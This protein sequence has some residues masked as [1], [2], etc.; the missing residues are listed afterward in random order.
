MNKEKYPP[1]QG[2]LG[3]RFCEA[4]IEGSRAVV[5]GLLDQ[6]GG[7]ASAIRISGCSER[8]A[9]RL[10]FTV[11]DDV[12]TLLE[13]V[14]QRPASPEAVWVDVASEADGSYTITAC[15]QCETLSDAISL[16]ASMAG[17]AGL[18]SME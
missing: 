5:V 12:S 16:I 6:R 14:L 11:H 1:P 7:T 15:G 9:W 10:G 3:N 13:N 17:Y 8:E 2:R 4:E 18:T